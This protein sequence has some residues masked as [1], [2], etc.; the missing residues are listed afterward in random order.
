MGPFPNVKVW[1]NISV[2]LAQACIYLVSFYKDMESFLPDGK[3]ENK[4]QHFFFII[5]KSTVTHEKSLS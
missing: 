4:M 5:L 2:F 1:T 3:L